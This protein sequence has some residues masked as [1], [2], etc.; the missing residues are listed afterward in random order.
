[1]LQASKVTGGSLFCIQSRGFYAST[2]SDVPSSKMTYYPT[3][4]T[5]VVGIRPCDAHGA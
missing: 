2:V 1:M 3:L 4:V 5:N